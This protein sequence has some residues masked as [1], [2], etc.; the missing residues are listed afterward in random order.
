MRNIWLVTVFV[1]SN[2]VVRYGG[3]AMHVDSMYDKNHWVRENIFEIK[4]RLSNLGLSLDAKNLPRAKNVI[5][6]IGDGM[7]L[8]TLTSARI[9]KGQRNH[10]SGEM[11]KLIWDEFPSIAHVKTFTANTMVGESAACATAMF[12]GVKTNAEVIGFDGKMQYNNCSTSKPTKLQTIFDWAQEAGMKTGFVTTTRV[13]HATPAALYAHTSNRYW[14]D[15]SK[16]P[17]NF[18]KNCKDITRQLVESTPGRNINVI[19]GGGLR[20][21]L[22]LMPPEYNQTSHRRSSKEGKRLDSRNLVYE[23]LKDKQHKGFKAK[24]VTTRSEMFQISEEVDFLLGLFSYSH[25]EYH[26]D[27][28]KDEETREQPT[29]LEMTRQALE[30]LKFNSSGFMLVVESGRID[31]AH[32]HNNAFR[33]LD[34]T[35]ALEEAVRDVIENDLID[36]K[37]TL[38]LVTADHAEGMIFSGYNSPIGTDIMGVDRSTS[39]VDN[40]HYPVLTY[41]AGPGHYA[42]ERKKHS[43]ETFQPSTIPKSWGNHGGEDVPLFAVGPLSSTLFTG[44][45]DQTYIPQAISYALCISIHSDRCNRHDDLFSASSEE[46]EETVEEENKV[47]DIY[48][49][50]VERKEMYAS[51]LLVNNETEVEMQTNGTSNS[52]W[53][54]SCSNYL[55]FVAFSAVF[56]NL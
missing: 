30:V 45:F 44:T 25:L 37:E 46:E 3:G 13:S 41:A 52:D 54:P 35:L 34:E 47:F 17:V 6:F 11:E 10:R 21:W 48:N 22:P 4:K 36:L 18:R 55:F 33:A 53:R 14:E 40:K 43:K 31:H 8:N 51:L 16:V 49:S 2:I 39:D 26:A 7:G 23:W 12:T 24:Y 32:H 20:S 50:H 1:L 29:L 28:S 38:I 5:L 19:M 56:V 42:Y 15:D 27:R 9:L